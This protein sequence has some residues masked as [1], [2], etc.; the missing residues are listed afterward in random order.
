MAPVTS[1]ST[2]TILGNILFLTN[3][4]T[5]KFYIVCFN[6]L[7]LMC[8]F[9][10]MVPVTTKTECVLAHHRVKKL[11]IPVNIYVLCKLHMHCCLPKTLCSWRVQALGKLVTLLLFPGEKENEREILFHGFHRQSCSLCTP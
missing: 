6:R 5:G 7:F 11:Q 9:E 1:I 3:K 10:Y 2:S 4:G 8:F